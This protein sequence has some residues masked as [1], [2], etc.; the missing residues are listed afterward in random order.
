MSEKMYNLL[1]D[2]FRNKTEFTMTKESLDKFMEEAT[3]KIIFIK[4]QDAIKTEI[5][6]TYYEYTCTILI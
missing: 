2:V 4:E 6:A 5:L 1:T 3:F